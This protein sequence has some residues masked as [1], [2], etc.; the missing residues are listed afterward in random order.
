MRKG[1]MSKAYSRYVRTLPKRYSRSVE[2]CLL[3]KAAAVSTM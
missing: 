1:F 2:H 3:M